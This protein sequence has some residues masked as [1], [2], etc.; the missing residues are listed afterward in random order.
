MY[1]VAIKTVPTMKLVTVE[2]VGSYMQIGEAFETLFY[3]LGE[4]AAVDEAARVVGVFFDDIDVV[5]ENELRSLAGVVVE[6]NAQLA[7]PLKA[8]EIAGGSY[9]VLR[10]KGPYADMKPAY[11]W[12]FGSWLVQS[13]R[14]A[15]NVPVFE[16]YLNNPRDTAPP[17]LLTDIYLPLA[18]TE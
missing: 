2:H 1:D 12:F 4:K 18:A 6:G 10:H 8:A 11:E 7:P 3:K 5:P 9:A 14:E 16:E 13:G 17:E 15:A